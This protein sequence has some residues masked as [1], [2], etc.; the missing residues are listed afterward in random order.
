VAVVTK[1]VVG[2]F[3]EVV[4]ASVVAAA[5][6]VLAEVVMGSAMQCRL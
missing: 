2:R 3:S 6:V 1:V 4:V 5:A